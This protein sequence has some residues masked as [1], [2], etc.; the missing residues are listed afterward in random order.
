MPLVFESRNWVHG[1]FV[2]ACV[3][4]EA[5][6]AAEH[7]GTA[8]VVL[9]LVFLSVHCKFGI[10]S[11]YLGKQI[12]HDPMAM[13]PFMGYNFG[14]YMRHWMKLGQPPHKVTSSQRR[15]TRCFIVRPNIKF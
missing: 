6:A 13:R 7:A 10:A 4:S 11:F 5:T 3:K 15:K 14:R 2:G 12:M 1:I 9:P 8:W